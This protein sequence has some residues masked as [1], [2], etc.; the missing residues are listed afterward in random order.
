MQGAIELGRCAVHVMNRVPA[1]LD[2][3]VWSSPRDTKGVGAYR[4][5]RV[6]T[7]VD[8]TAFL[9]WDAGFDFGLLH[10]AFLKPASSTGSNLAGAYGRPL[11]ISPSK[12]FP[13]VDTPTMALRVDKPYDTATFRVSMKPQTVDAPK[14]N[15]NPALLVPQ[16]FAFR[17]SDP[18]GLDCTDQNV[19]ACVTVVNRICYD[20]VGM[21]GTREQINDAIDASQSSF[22]KQGMAKTRGRRRKESGSVNGAPLFIL[23]RMRG[24]RIS[25]PFQRSVL[26]LLNFSKDPLAAYQQAFQLDIAGAT[27][28]SP[29]RLLHAYVMQQGYDAVAAGKSVINVLLEVYQAA[30][31]VNLGITTTADAIAYFRSFDADRMSETEVICHHCNRSFLLSQLGWAG[32]RLLCSPCSKEAGVASAGYIPTT[33]KYSVD[34]SLR[35]LWAQEAKVHELAWDTKLQHKA[36]LETYQVTRD[37]YMDGYN[38]TITVNDM[39]S[40]MSCFDHSFRTLTGRQASNPLSPSIDGVYRRWQKNNAFH[41]HHPENVVV[42]KMCVNFLKGPHCPSALPIFQRSHALC[43]TVKSQPPV[44]GYHAE[45]AYEMETIELASDNIYVIGAFQPFRQKT[46][47]SQPTLLSDRDFQVKFIAQEKSGAWDGMSLPWDQARCLFASRAELNTQI[48][49]T[50]QRQNFEMWTQDDIEVLLRDVDQIE[51]DVER[52]N[53]HR[54]SIPRGRDGRTPLLWRAGH[55][56]GDVDMEFMFREFQAR[57]WTWDEVCDENNETAESPATLFIEY[58]VQWFKTGGKW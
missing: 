57:L 2:T 28:N 38:G 26:D 43:E 21:V 8:V 12:K 50:A 58:V 29:H 49:T 11:S 55:M 16:T 15:S 47:V 27:V 1:K 48:P 3:A 19:R 35:K 22:L 34:H 36:I 33:P 31:A 4:F 18:A 30:D 56:P 25:I 44:V 13:I 42:T 51:A 9:M 32:E 37:S 46:R 10:S 24:R 5:S 40:F 17:A 54:L 23:P 14:V 39:A 53:S 7:F 45:I 6:R 41:I 20:L 52:F